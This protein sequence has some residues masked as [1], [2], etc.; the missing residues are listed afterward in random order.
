MSDKL[1][2][3]LD[4]IFGPYAGL[5]N[6]KEL[7]EEL[8]RD[9]LEKMNDLI[10]QGDD[11]ESALDKTINSIGDISELVGEVCDNTRNLQM[12]TGI[13][14]SMSPL[15]NSDMKNVKVIEG[16]F[17]YTDL[18]GSDFNGSILRGCVFKCANLTDCSFDGADL[19]DT[20]FNKSDLRRSRFENAKIGNT[21]FNLSDLKDAS[22]EGLKIMNANFDYAGLKKTN[23]KNT[24]LINVSFKTDVKKTVFDG[25][26]MDKLTYAMLKGFGADLSKVTIME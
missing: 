5:D 10:K 20:E 12:H 22:F 3:H 23:F 14:L 6:I 2:S 11:V 8:Y 18:A 1:R 4:K 17:N 15:K 7:K 16:K 19:T 9:F 13:D 21:S 24:I 26:M 25:A